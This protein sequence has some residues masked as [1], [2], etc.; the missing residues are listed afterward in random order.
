MYQNL[1][2]PLLAEFVGSH[3][4]LDL[5]QGQQVTCVSL[6]EGAL[7]LIIAF[8]HWFGMQQAHLEKH[9]TKTGMVYYQTSFTNQNKVS[10]HQ[11]NVHVFSTQNFPHD[12]MLL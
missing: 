8:Y 7:S 1:K 6:C 11:Y 5:A 10:S 3:K 9:L 12:L 2:V 4:I